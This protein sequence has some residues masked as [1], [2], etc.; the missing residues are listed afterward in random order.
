MTRYANNLGKVMDPWLRLSRHSVLGD[1]NHGEI[2]VIVSF[3]GRVKSRL[4]ALFFSYRLR[5]PA[6]EFLD[7]V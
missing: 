6:G 4:S 5:C 1:T 7:S 2:T 3:I